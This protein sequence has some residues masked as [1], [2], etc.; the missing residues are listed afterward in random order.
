MTRHELNKNFRLPETISVGEVSY[1]LKP[2]GNLH[3]E[4]MLKDEPMTDHY[5]CS[6][7]TEDVTTD[8]LKA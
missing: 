2:H 1:E 5:R 7:T 4:I 3:I 6:V 8:S